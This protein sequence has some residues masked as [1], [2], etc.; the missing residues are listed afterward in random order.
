MDVD[1]SQTATEAQTALPQVSLEEVQTDTAVP[2]ESDTAPVEP[3]FVPPLNEEDAT[4]LPRLK[5]LT[6]QLQAMDSWQGPCQGVYMFV[7]DKL[8]RERRGLL[9]GWRMGKQYVAALEQ[10]T[11]CIPAPSTSSCMDMKSTKRHWL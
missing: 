3:A 2:M 1:E 8:E 10:K 11:A 4:R 6:F 7:R 5:E 9:I